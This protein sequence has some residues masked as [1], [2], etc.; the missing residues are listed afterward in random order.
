MQLE[1][2]LQLVRQRLL[3]EPAQPEVGVLVALDEQLERA[4]LPDGGGGEDVVTYG[5]GMLSSGVGSNK[6]ET[7]QGN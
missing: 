2:C 3:L 1:L 4:H 7:V 6:T 5:R